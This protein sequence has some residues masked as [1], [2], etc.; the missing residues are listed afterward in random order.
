MV[1]LILFALFSGRRVDEITRLRWADLEGDRILVREMKHP[2]QLVDTW[3]FLTDRALAIIARQPREGELIFPF[4]SKSI[5]GAFTRMC[6]YLG[7]EDLH[8]HDLRHECASW[9]FELGLDIPRVAGITGHRSWASLQR[10]THLRDREP[11][12]KYAGWR[13]LP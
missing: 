9:L 11:V 2:R 10:Y 13:W 12:D 7:I 5:S 6:Q 3:V 4:N 8:F 1:E